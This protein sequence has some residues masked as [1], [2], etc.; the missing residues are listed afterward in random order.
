MGKK[1]RKMLRAVSIDGEPMVANPLLSLP[2]N[3]ACPCGS[4]DKFKKCCRD[5]TKRYVRKDA[6]EEYRS[7]WE[8]A[9][10]GEVAW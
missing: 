7:T 1:G 8:A 4:G 2:R 5:L 3:M 10:S 9:M 6:L